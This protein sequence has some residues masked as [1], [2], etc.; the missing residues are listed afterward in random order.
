MGCFLLRQREHYQTG[1]V[2]VSVL[3]RAISYG[4]SLALS[5]TCNTNLRAAAEMSSEKPGR[6][7]LGRNSCRRRS[8]AL[9]SVA[10]TSLLDAEQLTFLRLKFFSANNTLVH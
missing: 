4:H 2:P 8:S 6:A 1:L 5:D 7:G 3:F 10:W 9:S